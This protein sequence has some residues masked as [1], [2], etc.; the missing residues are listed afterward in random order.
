MIYHVDLTIECNP[1]FIDFAS[2]FDFS[3]RISAFFNAISIN[4]APAVIYARCLGV[5]GEFF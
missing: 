3:V 4:G 1:I 2:F 5:D